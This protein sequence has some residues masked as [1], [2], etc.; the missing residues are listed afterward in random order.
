MSKKGMALSVYPAP[1]ILKELKSRKMIRMVHVAH[2]G[3]V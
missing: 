3:E 1:N 2:V